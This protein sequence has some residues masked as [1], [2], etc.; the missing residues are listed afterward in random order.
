MKKSYFLRSTAKSQHDQKDNLVSLPARSKRSWFYLND[1]YSV[2][3]H[4]AFTIALEEWYQNDSRIQTKKW[5]NIREWSRE[6]N[7][8]LRQF[9]MKKKMEWPYSCCFDRFLRFPLLYPLG[10]H[11]TYFQKVRC[12]HPRHKVDVQ[13]DALIHMKHVVDHVKIDMPS[14]T[15]VLMGIQ[16]N[17]EW[18]NYYELKYQTLLQY[19]ACFQHVWWDQGYVIYDITTDSWNWMPRKYELQTSISRM[20]RLI[21]KSKRHCQY[22]IQ[23][24][25]VL[26]PTFMWPNMKMSRDLWKEE[27]RKRA[28]RL[29]ELTLLWN[30][31]DQQRQQLWKRGIYSWKQPEFS[32]QQFPFLGNWKKDVLNRMIR[33]HQQSTFVMGKIKHFQQ[34]S[35]SQ[36]ND[37]R[38]NH[39]FLDFEYTENGC[40]YL[41]GILDSFQ[42]QYCTFWAESPLEEEMALCRVQRWIQDKSPVRIWYWHIDRSIW[43]Q[44]SKQYPSLSFDPSLSIEWIDLCDVIRNT[45]VFK[46]S[47]DFGLKSIVQVLYKEGLFH[48]SYEDLSIQT[49]F[50][51]LRVI[52]D[53]WKQHRLEWKQQLETYNRLD[54]I[55]VAAIFNQL[56]YQQN[57][58]PIESLYDSIIKKGNS[59]R[60]N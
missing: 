15:F 28:E 54:C 45:M 1:L 52:Q 53:Y 47:F 46:G 56:Y 11:Q 21:R 20:I 18:S 57:V 34:S 27:K 13:L 12:Q 7:T 39:V 44:K 40:V 30:I 17:H 26:L 55:A 24:E 22:Y 23:E 59:S 33:I 10:N 5:S 25:D 48:E 31:T 16:T 58:L 49:G 8:Q 37:G 6:R 50:D 4:D 42:N 3:N 2:W 19:S 51:S 29:G 32:I 14:D 36:L 43:N 38:W 60:I 41:T 9:Y 35:Y